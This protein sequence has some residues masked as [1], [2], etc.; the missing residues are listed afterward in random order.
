MKY[1]INPICNFTPLFKIDYSKKVNIV[2]CVFFKMYN[3]GYKDFQNYTNGLVDLSIYVK[4]N[5]SDYK[6]R[7]F[8]DD[9]VYN[10]SKL[11][12]QIKKLDNVQLVKFSCSEYLMEDLT[13]HY[14]IF[15]TI[16]RFFPGFDFQ[17]NDTNHVLISD[18][19][20]IS[21]EK[22]VD[23]VN[24]LKEKN[25]LDELFIVTSG[26][27]CY[28]MLKDNQNI[29]Y[30]KHI[31]TY[32][33][34]S[35]FFFVKKLDKNLIFDFLDEMKLNP[36]KSYSIFFDNKNV[37]DE[38]NMSESQIKKYDKDANKNFI[39]GVDEYFLNRVVIRNI[40]DNNIP[41]ANHIKFDVLDFLKYKLLLS[42]TTDNEKQKK[43]VDLLFN[44]ILTENN[45]KN[46]IHKNIKEKYYF[47]MNYIENKKNNYVN[48]YYKLYEAIIYLKNN[49]LYSFLFTSELY[50]FLLDDKNF[51][52]Y[53][54]K[55]I[56][57]Y[58]T[59][60]TNINIKNSFFDGK[61]IKKIERLLKNDHLLNDE[62]NL[63]NL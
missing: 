51:G 17:Y 26:D 36:E 59:K 53:F 46:K 21:I 19:D 24:M 11:M 61:Y 22:I 52:A 15:P 25:I 57:I 32:I 27:I 37:S 6:I 8:I 14:G 42:K 18:I 38:K 49:N 40:I 34:A 41:Y 47:L 35:M 45:F 60:Y 54:I 10:D 58:N 9:S 44:Y 20:S 39:Y 30:N 62:L 56:Y 55:N 43:F 33:S 48:I 50:D 3:K 13:H 63:K 29:F 31:N 12:S 28:T 5:L 23:T 2:S 7:L 4:N 1:L 16:V